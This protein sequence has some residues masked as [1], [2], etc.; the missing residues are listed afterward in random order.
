METKTFAEILLLVLF[1]VTTVLGLLGVGITIIRLVQKKD[2]GCAQTML[3]IVSI[4][5]AIVTGWKTF[6]TGGP[7]SLQP[8]P[9]SASTVEPTVMPINAPTSEPTNIPT[10][11]HNA[12]ERTMRILRIE[13]VENLHY[14]F[15]DPGNNSLTCSI[16]FP[17]AVFGEYSFSWDLSEQEKKSLRNSGRL[18]RDNGEEVA[19]INFWATSDGVFAAGIPKD[20]LP[21]PYSYKLILSINDVEYSDT[22]SFNYG[23]MEE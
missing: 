6:S 19:D 8:T 13:T 15:P 1:L 17:L 4:L 10:D 22:I 23:G 7:E 2:I 20:L 11:G 16:D 14:D 18:F 21:G 9:T 12:Q 5:I 3:S